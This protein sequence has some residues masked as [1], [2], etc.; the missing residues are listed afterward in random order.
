MSHIE[1]SFGRPA[2]YLRLSVT[3]RCN[4]RCVYCTPSTGS[5][6]A[7]VGRLMTLGEIERLVRVAAH[8]GVRRVRIT[9]GEPLMRHDLPLLIETVAKIDGIEEVSLTTNGA[10]LARYADALASAG[11]R[12]VNVSLDSLDPET[13]AAIRRGGNLLHV[14]QGI[15]A[16]ARAGLF[17]IKINMVPIRGVNDGEIQ[18]FAMLTL[19]SSVHVRFIELMPSSSVSFW[20][21]ERCVPVSDMIRIVSTISPLVPVGNSDS[22]PARTFQLAG[23]QGVIGFISP[24]THPFCG[25]CNRIRLTADGRIR[26]CLFSGFEVDVLSVVRSGKPDREVEACFRNALSSKPRR[27]ALDAAGAGHRRLAMSRIGG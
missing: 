22:G 24:M 6:P 16:A 4:L 21:P 7:E 10:R 19:E 17:P 11:L 18:R 20:N 9:G 8:L 25:S 26:P 14:L 15:Q 2:S 5:Q 27:H 13:Y 1:D 12:R 23:A 3:D